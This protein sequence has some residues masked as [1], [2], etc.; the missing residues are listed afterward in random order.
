MALA[1]RI[2]FFSDGCRVAG[3]SDELVV[4]AVGD[5]LFGFGFDVA[6]FGEEEGWIA[7]RLFVFAEG[8][9]ETF[10]AVGAAAFADDLEL[11][12][13]RRVFARDPFV[14]VA[15]ASLVGGD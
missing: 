8:D 15:E 13:V 11:V 2:A 10:D 12:R 6:W 5:D 7:A 4:G 1:A 14:D 3:L 9:G